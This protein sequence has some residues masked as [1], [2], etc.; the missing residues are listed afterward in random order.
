MKH[1][2]KTG[3]NTA[4]CNSRRGALSNRRTDEARMGA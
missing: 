2:K 3:K 1:G 4:H